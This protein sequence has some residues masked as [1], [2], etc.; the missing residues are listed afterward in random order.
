MFQA[1]QNKALN[2]YLVWRPDIEPQHDGV[3]LLAENSEEAALLFE[4]LHPESETVACRVM[5]QRAI[6][7]AASRSGWTT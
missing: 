2:E 3:A 4:Q 1:W 6:R 7:M 5:F